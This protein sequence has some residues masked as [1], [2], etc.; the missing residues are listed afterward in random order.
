MGNI[1]VNVFSLLTASC[2][3]STLPWCSVVSV[4]THSLWDH[5]QWRCH[6]KLTKGK[7]MS[8]ATS[9]PKLVEYHPDDCL[10]R[11]IL[12]VVTR[13]SFVVVPDQ[14]GPDGV[15]V[16]RPL[17]QNVCF[18][19]GG[20][21]CSVLFCEYDC[22]QAHQRMSVHCCGGMETVNGVFMLK[23][24][25][26]CCRLCSNSPTN[27]HQPLVATEPV[28]CR[29]LC[30]KLMRWQALNSSADLPSMQGFCQ[31]NRLLC[32]SELEQVPAMLEV[33]Q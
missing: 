25:R 13:V 5:N 27:S 15:C 29:Q 22:R 18:V 8:A 21:F 31:D 33:L 32:S 20:L 7:L 26:T 11:K 14:W 4:T 17:Q 30:C 12:F 16:W 19:F 1:I 9:Q 6:N 10:P 2:Q 23:V 24:M 3:E 28:A